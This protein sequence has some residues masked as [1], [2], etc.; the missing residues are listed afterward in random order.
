AFGASGDRPTHNLVAVTSRDGK[1][2]AAH[3]GASALSVG[4]GWHD[5]IH[6]VPQ[7]Q[8]YLQERADR[9]SIRNMIYVIP[10]D[11]NSL[12]QRFHQ[13]FPNGAGVPDITVSNHKDGGL[14]VAPRSP[15]ESPLDLSLD[16][17]G[18][19]PSRKA[20]GGTGR[21]SSPWGGF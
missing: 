18:A 9:I 10:N 15:N 20:S 6:L 8:A 16:V 1:W 17:I 14:R 3:G 21:K 19:A 13:D 11:K 12:L 4:N 2:L 7:V 5:C